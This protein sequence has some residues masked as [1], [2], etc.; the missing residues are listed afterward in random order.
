MRSSHPADYYLSCNTERLLVIQMSASFCLNF[1]V[2][3]TFACSVRFLKSCVKFIHNDRGACLLSPF[4][5]FSKAAVSTESGPLRFSIA[6]SC[7]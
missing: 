4:F 2:P 5:D 1:S 3:K 7:L 6:F